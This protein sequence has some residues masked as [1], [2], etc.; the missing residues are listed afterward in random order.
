M[1]V[2]VASS[3]FIVVRELTEE[4]GTKHCMLNI[5]AR[6]T[7][8]DRETII[9][10][11]KIVRINVNGLYELTFHKLCPASKKETVLIVMVDHIAEDNVSVGGLSWHIPG[12]N[13]MVCADG[14][15]YIEIAESREKATTRTSKRP[16]N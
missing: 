13:K 8:T 4:S 16:K 11:P 2:C 6:E 5:T 9:K 10:I 1:C 7:A 14:C 3:M 12:A 15:K